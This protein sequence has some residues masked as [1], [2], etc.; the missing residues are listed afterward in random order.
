MKINVLGGGSEIGASCLHVEMAETSL[1]IDAGMRMKGEQVLPSFGMLD[2]LQKPEAILVTHAHADHIGALP[3][4]HGLVPDVPIFATPPTADLMKI[5]T[6]DSYKILLEQTRLNQTLMPYTEEQVDQM[7]DAVRLLPAKNQLHIGNLKVT[8]FRAGHILGAVM[9]LIEGDGESLLVTGD[10]SFRGGRTIPSAKVPQDVH[11]DVVVM[12]STYGNRMH[13]DRNMEE[14]RLADHVAEVVSNGGFALIPAF[15]LGRAQ[16][17]LLILQDYMEKGLIPSFPIYVDGLVTPV[18]RIYK[19]YPQFLKGPVAHRIRTNGDAFLTEG[20]CTAVSAKE[21]DKILQGKPGCIVASS[22]MLTG[23]ASAWYAQQLVSGEKN[24]IFITGYQDEE[25]P[26]RKLLALA[27]GE[28]NTLDIDGRTYI[29][30]CR[31]DKYGLSAHA[32]AGE[33]TRLIETLNPTYTLLVHGDEDARTALSERIHPR[34]HPLL[35]ENGEAYPFE[36][37]RSGKGV[38]GKRYHI[39]RE[40][41]KLRENIG[42]VLLYHKEDDELLRFVLCMNVHPKTST[43]VCEDPKGK[44]IKIANHQVADVIGPWNRSIDELTTAADKVSRFSRPYLENIDWDAIPDRIL[45]IQEVFRALRLT[46]IEKQLAV[47]LALQSISTDHRHLDREGTVGYELDETVKTALRRFEYPIQGL[48]MNRNLAMDVVREL[49]DKHPRF[50]RCGIEQNPAGGEQL[51]ISFD[52]PDGVSEKERQQIADEVIRNTG[53]PVSF[54]ESVRA[55][56]FQ[57]CIESLLGTD[58]DNPSVH[59]HEKYVEIKE[60]KPEKSAEIKER[61][62]QITGFELRF[63]NDSPQQNTYED[64]EIFQTKSNREPMENNKAIAEAKK[65]A[66]ERQVKVYKTSMKQHNGAPMMELHFISPEVAER[67]KQD[68]RELSERIG[69]EVTYARQPKQNELIRKT[70]EEIPAEWGLKGNPSLYMDQKM[71]TVKLTAEPDEDTKKAVSE[72]L[73]EQTG[74]MLEIQS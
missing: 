69:W 27:D 67:Y 26:G 55:D 4:V 63:S 16:E 12:E 41:E 35:S 54:S 23:G 38:I 15:A 39:S 30:Q 53:W 7:L 62:K 9:F 6:R 19:H 40:Q 57:P 32:D 43:L 1:L 18:S 2:D 47:A 14:K 48:Q 3:V 68:L 33:M 71:I 45:S 70:K 56:A 74:Y 28:E 72:A 34:F 61:F 13:T 10:L 24:A 17:V 49:L 64:Q 37:R 29:V 36:K 8:V 31:V 58:I 59:I 44:T 60:M 22:G 50:V 20:R 46:E 42:Q 25:S 5:M 11:P 52:F 65:W 51:V 73:E 21:R 66:N